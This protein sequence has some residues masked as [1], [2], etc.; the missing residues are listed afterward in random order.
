LAPKPFPS[1]AGNGAHIHFSLWDN[2]GKRNLMYDAND[3]Y[4]LSKLGHH[5]IAGILEHLPGLLALTCPSYN[6][7]RRL[8]PHF[9][10]SAFTAWG[11]D[12][13]EAAVRVP[14]KFKSD[15]SGSTNAELKASDSSSNPYLALGGLLAA[16]L[17]GVR[18]EL[19]PVAPVLIDPANYSDAERA[20]RGIKRFPTSLKEA[21]QQLEADSVLIEA[22]GSLLATSYL[23]VKTLEWESFS[24][25]DIDFELKHHFW[26]F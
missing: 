5:F 3:P 7:Y 15:P 18:R 13:R 17:D 23:A 8:Q 12:N 2:A 24:Q 14:S 22:L 25:Q 20:E 1:E 6:S 21:L 16:G 11:P 26:K 19:A 9:W 10:S 4:G